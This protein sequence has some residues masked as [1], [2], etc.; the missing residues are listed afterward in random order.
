MLDVIVNF[1]TA[2]KWYVILFVF[3]AKVIEVTLTTIRIIIVNRGFKMPGAI[4]SFIEVLI[5]VFV[6][7]EV[8]KEVN[9]APILGITYA[10][11]YAVGV[12][13]GSIVE[14]KL[15]FGKVLL[16]VIIP[17]ESEEIVSN[18][19]RGQKIGLT[20]ID[21]KGYNSDKLVLMM[22]ANRKNIDLIKEEIM[23]LEPH[24]LI[25]ESDVVTIDG[26]TVPKKSRII[27]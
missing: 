21:A 1:F 9:T 8:V 24:A 17:L 3:A 25:G 22:Y 5:W 6:A 23:R 14:R 26:G 18:Y 7:S 15:A 13:V 2:A 11:G 19:I 27:K 10:L 20:T 12:Y 16:H 4:V